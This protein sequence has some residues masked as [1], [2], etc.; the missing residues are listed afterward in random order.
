[1]LRTKKKVKYVSSELRMNEKIENTA[2]RTNAASEYYPIYVND[3]EDHH[4]ALFTLSE[5]QNAIDRGSKNVED[6]VP[7]AEYWITRLIKA[8][9][10]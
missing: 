9:I 6:T 5:I 1:M 3:G 4:Y 7:R 2:R 10:I 8:I